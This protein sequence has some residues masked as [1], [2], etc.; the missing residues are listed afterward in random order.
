MLSFYNTEIKQYIACSNRKPFHLRV[1]FQYFYFNIQSMKQLI[2]IINYTIWRQREAVGPGVSLVR[3]SNLSP[4]CLPVWTS[5]PNERV[6]AQERDIFFLLFSLLH[7]VKLKRV[8]ADCIKKCVFQKRWLMQGTSRGGRH[9]TSQGSVSTWGEHKHGCTPSQML[10]HGRE[11]QRHVLT[12]LFLDTCRQVA[13]H[14]RWHFQGISGSFRT[15]SHKLLSRYLW[16][17][18]FESLLWYANHMVKMVSRFSFEIS[19]WSTL[20]NFRM[21]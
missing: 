20:H 12:V 2:T 19:S 5:K 10:C 6:K 18:L 21:L 7:P 17:A 16:T 4:A 9:F 14:R 1:S 3:S 8:E 11:W 13:V 15:Q